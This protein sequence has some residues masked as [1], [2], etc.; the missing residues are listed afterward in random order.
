MPITEQTINPMSQ[1]L[2]ALK[3]PETKRQWPNRLKVVFD[4][5]GF[6]GN[7]D[8]QAKQFMTLCKEGGTASVQDKI[9]GLISY[10]VQRAQ[11][12]EI[13]LSTIPNY[14]KA[15][16]LFCEMNDIHI[17]WRKISRGV[18]RGRQAAND[19]APTKEEIQRLLEYPD[20]RIKPIV[21]TMISSGIRIGAWDSLKW[22]HVKPIQNENGEVV[23]AKLTVYANDAE[24]YYSFITPEAYKTL[25]DWMDFR[26]SYGEA[27]T[28][29]SWLM[30]DIW[31]TTNMNYWAKVG[32]ATA[33]KRLKSSGIKR[34]LERALWEQGIREVLKEGK[35]RHEWKAAHGFR[36]FYKTHAEQVMKPINVEI[37]MGHSI[38]ISASYYKPKE[39]DILEDYLHAVDLLTINDT[40]NKL[41]S[42]LS[43]ME[44]IG[45]KESY[46]IK[47]KLYEKEHEINL[48]R[49]RD[50][51]NTDAIS[52][53]S[54]KLA[55]VIRE[56]EAL[57]NKERSGIVNDSSNLQSPVS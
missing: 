35:R 24:Q 18:P 49:Q 39:S 28:D 14:L 2:Y 19:R 10:Q 34:L 51:M 33:P 53:L 6:P 30:R 47:G 20:R 17:S 3:A 25:K 23:A 1:F 27:I 48:L 36:K 9:I 41:R 52:A 50:E 15:M 43:E 8:E 56:I 4:F 29:E 44:Q 42:R 7:L 12:G 45:K 5:L 31:Q 21:Y 55:Y 46:V 54:D 37:T 26:V 16:K 40:D 22:K 13:S 57:K 32:L 11:K 38:G